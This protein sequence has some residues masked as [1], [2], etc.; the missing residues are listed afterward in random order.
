MALG[1]PQSPDGFSATSAPVGSPRNLFRKWDPANYKNRQ[2][3]I[4][5][6]TQRQS[7]LSIPALASNAVQQSE[8]IRATRAAQAAGQTGQPVQ[9]SQP[10]A[11]GQRPQ[12]PRGGQRGVNALPQKDREALMTAFQNVF[13]Y[14]GVD[15]AQKMYK[16]TQKQMQMNFDLRQALNAGNKGAEY[17]LQGLLDTL[18]GTISLEKGNKVISGLNPA[19]FKPNSVGGIQSPI[20]Q[21]LLDQ[22]YKI[23]RSGTSTGATSADEATRQ[24]AKFKGAQAK[25]PGF[26][27]QRQAENVAAAKKLVKKLRKQGKK[28]VRNGTTVYVS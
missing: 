20:Y 27:K 11:T 21:E 2:A 16:P 26:K 3:R 23:V 4:A 6:L 8:A 19:A 13:E 10:T 7:Q 25:N 12:G 18:Q 14:S 22:G 17:G 1:I 24:L 28:A 9:V 15:P 5:A